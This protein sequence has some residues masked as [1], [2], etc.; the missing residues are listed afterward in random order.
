[1]VPL[2]KKCFFCRVLLT[3]SG[4][5]AVVEMLPKSQSFTWFL[6][7]SNRFSNFT[8]LK[9]PTREAQAGNYFI[10]KLLPLRDTVPYL[11]VQLSK[12]HLMYMYNTGGKK[13]SLIMKGG[14]VTIRLLTRYF[15][16]WCGSGYIPF[17]FRI[18]DPDPG[19]QWLRIRLDRDPLP[20]HFCGQCKNYVVKQIVNH[21]IL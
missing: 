6:A 5:W 14:S 13:S 8:S 4:W 7:S 12:T 18:T 16:Q 21:Y 1:M 15:S 19:G 17:G 10:F 9:R 3:W 11:F 20:R 2:T